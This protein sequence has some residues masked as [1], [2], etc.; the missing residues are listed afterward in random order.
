MYLPEM[1]L[2]GDE[3]AINQQSGEGFQKVA[4]CQIGTPLHYH[5]LGYLHHVL[6]K[7]GQQSSVC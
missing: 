3:A 4:L 6:H 7:D 5:K 2:S 1:M